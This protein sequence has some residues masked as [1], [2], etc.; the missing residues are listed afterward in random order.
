[1]REEL[2]ELK[3]SKQKPQRISKRMLED[4]LHVYYN[5]HP[6]TKQRAFVLATQHTA[7]IADLREELDTTNE[8]LEVA[9]SNESS[10]ST[11]R[12]IRRLEREAATMQEKLTEQE[13][14]I[15]DLEEAAS[16]AT[17]AAAAAKK[18]RNKAATTGPEASDTSATAASI[19]WRKW[20]ERQGWFVAKENQQ[21]A[22]TQQQGVA[23]LRECAT[24]ATNNSPGLGYSTP[25]AGKAAV[26]NNYYSITGGSAALGRPM[27]AALQRNKMQRQLQQQRLRMQ[28]QAQ[29]ARAMQKQSFP[30]TLSLTNSF[31]TTDAM[32]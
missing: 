19:A 14:E 13:Q 29:M 27:G 30:K 10:S 4:R 2:K 21:P 17:R 23:P 3:V 31:G 20:G 1:M 11:D 16:C 12:R 18:V 32:W 15:E 6:K 24:N 8:A 7:D 9:K 26:T 5:D 22:P 28:M 25:G